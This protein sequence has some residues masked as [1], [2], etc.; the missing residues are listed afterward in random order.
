[1]PSGVHASPKVGMPPSHPRYTR[2]LRDGSTGN[3][4]DRHELDEKSPAVNVVGAEVQHASG[5]I[6]YS[7]LEHVLLGW[8]CLT[9][10]A[11]SVFNS[12]PRCEAGDGGGATLAWC[13]FLSV[14]IGLLDLAAGAAGSAVVSYR[15]TDHISDL[16]PDFQIAMG[17]H[18]NKMLQRLGAAASHVAADRFADARSRYTQ[19]KEY[20]DVTLTGHSLG[21]QLALH[22][23]RRHASVEDAFKSRTFFMASACRKSTSMSAR[24]RRCGSG[25]ISGDPHGSIRTTTHQ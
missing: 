14:V 5:T 18:Q 11:G 13:E 6:D 16:V 22:T 23:A 8:L 1:M 19:A 12:H 4:C 17:Y 15:G 20:D 25:T 3:G 2:T 10:W 24:L 21:G 9:L 7:R